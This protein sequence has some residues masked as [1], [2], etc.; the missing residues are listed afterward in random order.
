M[1]DPSKWVDDDKDKST[2]ELKLDE[3][4]FDMWKEFGYVYG[5]ELFVKSVIGGVLEE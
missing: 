2:D 1:R 4:I 5:I 3:D